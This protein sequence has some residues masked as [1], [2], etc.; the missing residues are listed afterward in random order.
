MKINKLSIISLIMMLTLL[1]VSCH[2]KADPLK[3]WLR[4]DFVG[5]LNGQKTYSIFYNEKVIERKGW[6]SMQTMLN[7]TPYGQLHYLELNLPSPFIVTAYFIMIVDTCQNKYCVASYTYLYEDGSAFSNTYKLNELEWTTP[8]TGSTGD[9]YI[10][11]V[12]EVIK[13]AKRG[14]PL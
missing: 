12:K 13:G 4:A 3:N 11:L 9:G 14:T 1:L 2:K 10:T 7:Y 6:V 8:D 5:T